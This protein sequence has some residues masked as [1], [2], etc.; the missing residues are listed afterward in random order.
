MEDFKV[1]QKLKLEVKNSRGKGVFN[2]RVIEVYE[3]FILV[4]RKNFKEC[5]LKTSFITGDIVIVGGKK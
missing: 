1:G 5:I 4:R 2:C 3:K